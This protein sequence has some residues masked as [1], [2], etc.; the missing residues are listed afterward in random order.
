[1]QFSPDD[2]DEFHAVKDVLIEEFRPWADEHYGADDGSLVAD[3]GTFLSWRFDYST[4]DLA[5][6]DT[7]DAD[8]FLLGWAPRKF[9]V[10]PEE[11]PT[12]C[13]SVQAMVEF[14]AV[15]RRLTGGI[16]RAARVMTHVDGLVDDVADALGDP[17]QF[18]LGK[19]LFGFR[20]DGSDGDPLADIY[21]LMASD[22]PVSVDEL[23]ALLDQR[24]AAFNSLPF[25]ERRA[26]TDP[27]L[28]RRPPKPVE[29]PFLLVPPRTEDVEASAGESELLR[30][31]DGLVRHLGGAGLKLTNN[32]NFR[33]SDARELVEV[34]DTGDE[35]DPVYFEQP[36][37]TRS[38]LDLT[39]LTF[40][41][42]VAALAGATIR[43]KTKLNADQA[44]L[45]RPLVER[46]SAVADALLTIGPLFTP[47]QRSPTLEQIASLLDEGV[48]HW[49]AGILP[50]G[51]AIEFD[52]IVAMA[53]EVAAGEFPAVEEMW[54]TERFEERVLLNVS[55]CFENVQWA[56][57]VSWSDSV[58]RVRPLT[59]ESYLA[60][61]TIALTTLGQHVM[62]ER[63]RA[64][65]YTVR[66]I[67]DLAAAEP[68]VLVNAVAAGSVDIDDA[69]SRWRPDESTAERA[70]QLAAAA[71]EADDAEQR[72]IAFRL[73]GRLEPIA[74]VGAT[75]RQLLDSPC[76]GHAA[77]FLLEH[78]LAT[79]DEVGM[80]VDIGPL[81]DMLATQ[82]DDPS[83]LDQLFRGVQARAIDDLIDD[84]WR[85]D[86]RE[87][88]P[89]LEALG[90]SL[91]DKKLAKAA[92]KAALQH[93]S[94]M[95]N[96]DL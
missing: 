89:V 5:D 95:A 43:L 11:A 64:A 14:L 37:K 96:K 24:M 32:G 33:L 18:G 46:A 27:M 49:L 47:W 30:Q 22:D 84:M 23:Q 75:V 81:V 66:S 57:I 4:G 90:R 51:A 50:A 42:E 85:H 13:R 62:P 29:L 21:S 38:S 12:L 55:K 59:G 39:R 1:M 8:E 44:W 25:D 9:A 20:L 80:F 70:R 78:E 58:E 2:S 63:V 34:L 69:L 40:I 65:H 86:Q 6:L 7:T 52:D 56:G 60:G 92:R 82:L 19:G 10:G 61:G 83:S 3:A 16:G 91:T 93:R 53:T 45:E 28:E 68:L 74:D 35:F 67:G 88:L 76:S 79:G 31:V 71:L 87:T 15:T 72:L 26:L 94:W 77:S 48:P 17:S 41:D 54:G 73:L 36:M